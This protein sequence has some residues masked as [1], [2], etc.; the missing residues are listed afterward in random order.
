MGSVTSINDFKAP[1]LMHETEAV[2]KMTLLFRK[3]GI[4]GVHKDLMCK[5]S[6]SYCL[7]QLLFD[8]T[9][10]SVTIKLKIKWLKYTFQCSI[11]F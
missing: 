9:A 4:K 2:H 7:M 3:S 1:L 11:G 10:K 6:S 5:G 8:C